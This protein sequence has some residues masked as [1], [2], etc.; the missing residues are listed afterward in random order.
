MFRFRKILFPV[1]FSDRCTAMLPYVGDLA[2]RLRA[3]LDFLH[4]LEESGAPGK[5]WRQREID[6]AAFAAQ[7]PKG[8]NCPQMVAYGTPAQTV[9]RYAR[10]R[11]VDIVA[12]PS[13]DRWAPDSVARDV[14]RQVSC[15]VW[16][17]SVAG[18]PH[19]RW[20]PIVCAVDLQQG[21][22]QVVSYASALAETFHASLV[23]V[24]AVS[25][26]AE[27]SWRRSSRWPAVSSRKG[28]Q[29]KLERLLQDLNVSAEP[30]VQTGSVEEVVGFAAKQ[31]SAEL[32]VVG[33][34]MQGESS[35][36]A[37]TYEL[38]RNSQCP[39]VACPRQP[40]RS[41]CFWTEWQ[42]DHSGAGTEASLEQTSGIAC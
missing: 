20:S 19:M 40:V 22:E 1:D 34:G 21:S 30:V 6:L 23:V 12:L 42:Q 9:A 7:I 11:A 29:R 25:D 39:V 26:I 18:H 38:V 32:L 31:A 27:D 15:A 16:T 4:V 36:G 8:L 33:R 24:H 17:G 13:N 10:N 28:G 5:L 41:E 35:L 3:D 14:L 2:D 37:H